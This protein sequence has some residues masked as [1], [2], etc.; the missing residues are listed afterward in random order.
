MHVGFQSTGAH[1]LDFDP[2]HLDAGERL[3]DLFQR[4]TSFIEDNLLQQGGGISHHGELPD[5]D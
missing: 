2:I 4:L 3:E 5:V 1:F